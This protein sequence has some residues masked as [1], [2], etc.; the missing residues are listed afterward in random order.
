MNAAARLFADDVNS[1]VGARFAAV[2]VIGW[3]IVPVAPSSSVTVNVTVYV[4]AAA[5]VC[6]GLAT[7][8]AAVPSPKFQA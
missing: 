2:T 4:P 5:Y 1:A 8:P 7:V 3:L 6:D